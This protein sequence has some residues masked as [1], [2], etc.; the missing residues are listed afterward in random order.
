[1]KLRSVCTE[2]LKERDVHEAFALA[3]EF[4]SDGQLVGVCPHGHRGHIGVQNYDC[5]ILFDMG[6]MA[7]LDGFN[8]EA[9]TAFAT[10]LE[11]TYEL[12]VRVIFQTLNPAVQH[13][14]GS[15]SIPNYN[16]AR[17]LF[18]RLW[19]DVRNQS[20]RQLGAF[21]ALYALHERAPAPLLSSDLVSFRNDCTHKGKIPPRAE[22]LAFGNA[23]L[24]IMEEIRRITRT[25]YEAALKGTWFMHVGRR[26]GASSGHPKTSMEVPTMV[27]WSWGDVYDT[28]LEARL[29]SLKKYRAVFWQA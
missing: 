2:C 27:R 24:T 7:L 14:D 13:D 21:A 1:M 6:G 20:E 15:M 11:R 5:E 19:K 16:E 18:D 26:F 28:A 29:E 17:A 22:T 25:K 10:A 4:T 8:R 23:V 3:V 9:V 12:Y